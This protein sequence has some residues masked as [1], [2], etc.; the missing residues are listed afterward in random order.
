M[1]LDAAI[2][3]ITVVLAAIAVGVNLSAA[4]HGPYPLRAMAAARSALACFYVAGYIWLLAHQERR[5]TWSK[6]MTGV[7]LVAWVVVWIL[8][9]LVAT[10]AGRP[11]KRSKR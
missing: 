3:A 6:M 9:A 1:S 5:V 8:P 7:S 11:A 4:R 2:I 10:K